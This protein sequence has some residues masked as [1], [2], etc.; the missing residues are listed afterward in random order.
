MLTSTAAPL[1]TTMGCHGPLSWSSDFEG[2]LLCGSA[3][4]LR[5]PERFPD[6]L[7]RQGQ[8]VH[9]QLGVEPKHAVAGALQ[10]FIPARI[11]ALAQQ[12]VA[13][14]HLDCEAR[15]GR[16]EIDD[17]TTDGHLPAKLHAEATTPNGLPEAL[18]RSGGSETHVPRSRGEQ[19]GATT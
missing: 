19:L 2:V 5:L 14:I 4:G 3:T 15:S 11:G 7:D 17:V 6:T 12:V 1:G 10:G 16:A 18:L 13:S 8:L 9:H